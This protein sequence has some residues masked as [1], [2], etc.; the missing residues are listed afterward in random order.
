MEVA[1]KRPASR[2]KA[3]TE[4]GVAGSHEREKAH[5]QPRTGVG[6][7]MPQRRQQEQQGKGHERHG[8]SREEEH[9][10]SGEGGEVLPVG[11]ADPPREQEP[12]CR[13]QDA[14]GRRQG[15]EDPAAPPPVPCGHAAADQGFEVRV[16]SRQQPG[17]DRQQDDVQPRPPVGRAGIGTHVWPGP[18][19]A[20]AL[21]PA[22]GHG[23]RSRAVGVRRERCG[24][25]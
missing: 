10:L 13:R 5:R 21:A 22:A 17:Q 18:R 24:W 12:L 19:Q 25:G 9:L 15:Q 20:S 6:E 23:G 4:G 3:R 11:I 14:V 7:P 2:R 8:P 1:S 16:R